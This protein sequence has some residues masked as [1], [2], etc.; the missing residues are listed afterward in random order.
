M[1]QGK[2]SKKSVRVWVLEERLSRDIKKKNG[3]PREDM[4]EP[5]AWDG[6]E[7]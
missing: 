7:N 2:G 6:E 1:G 3:Q 5:R 4:N